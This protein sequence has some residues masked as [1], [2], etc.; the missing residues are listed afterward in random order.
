MT[1]QIRFTYGFTLVEI[2]VSVAIIGILASIVTLNFTTQQVNARDSTRSSKATIIA[3]A[4]EKYYDEHGEYPSPKAI[5]GTY[6]ANTGPVVASLLSLAD[7][8]VLVMPNAPAGTT[9][10][11]ASALGSTD[12]IAYV[13]ASTVGNDNCQ[14]NASA[15]CEQFTLSYKKESDGSTVTINSTYKLRPDDNTSP[16]DAP[17]KPTI[18]AVQSGTNLIA[19]S[20]VPAC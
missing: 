3:A 20:S 11:L 12:V 10:S 18:A 4:L 13:A 8:D 16:L 6:G 19:T 7:K 17:A 2:L 1:R 5:L 15:G 9:N 14:N